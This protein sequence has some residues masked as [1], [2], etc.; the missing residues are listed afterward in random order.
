MITHSFSATGNAAA[1]KYRVWRLL[2][3]YRPAG[4]STSLRICCAC[5]GTR[6]TVWARSSSSMCRNLSGSQEGSTRV[7]PPSCG[8]AK[9][10][11]NPAPWYIGATAMVR[12]PGPRPYSSPV[13]RLVSTRL[14]WVRTTPLGRPVVPEV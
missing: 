2:R 8:P 13:A 9:A 1:V 12:R 4:S 10:K 7:Q 11:A 3:S 5:V 14:R 6:K